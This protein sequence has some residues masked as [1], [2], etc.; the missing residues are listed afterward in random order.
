MSCGFWKKGL[1]AM[2]PNGDAFGGW[3]CWAPL[4]GAVVPAGVAWLAE[5]DGGGVAAEGLPKAAGLKSAAK[6]LAA[7]SCP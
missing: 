3:D 1:D 6:G 2:F 7:G 4:D 5:E